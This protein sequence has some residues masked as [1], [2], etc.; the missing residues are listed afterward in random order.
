MRKALLNQRQ[1]RNF[2]SGFQH[3]VQNQVS[4]Q[5]NVQDISPSHQAQH[6][7]FTDFAQSSDQNVGG[8]GLMVSQS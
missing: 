5:Q 7:L 2:S 4:L 8:Q 1:A 6:H 3:Q